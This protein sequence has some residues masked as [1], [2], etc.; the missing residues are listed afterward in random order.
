MEALMPVAPLPSNA[1]FESNET[2]AR[3]LGRGKARDMYELADGNLLIVTTDRISAFDVI[4]PTPIPGKGAVLNQVS[5]FWFAKTSHLIANHL[6]DAEPF[7]G[8]PGKEHLR[9]RSVVVRR[10]RPLSIEAI[11]RGYL[12]GSGWA[13]YRRSGTVC[14][15]ALPEGLTES[16]QLPEP[17]FTPSTKAEQ[18]AHDENISFARAVELLGASL[19]A[20]VRD[21][22]LT[23]YSFAAAYAR[24]RGI[25]IA[26]TKFEFGQLDDGSLILIDEALTPDSSRFWPV[27]GYVPGRSQP[28]FDKQFVRD[29]LE[30]LGWA[31]KPPAPELPDEI[32]RK[33]AEKYRE[34]QRRLTGR[35]SA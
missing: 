13:E 22:A 26:D 28:S 33:T 15:I 31:K 11:V 27:D 16:A 23:L 35:E 17:L 18:G 29:Y 10:A 14:G 21:A 19:A 12:A 4:L 3:L 8:V 24:E 5:N 6:L 25:I 7:A 20:Q 1:L 2:D 34:A 30:S 9:G 32:V